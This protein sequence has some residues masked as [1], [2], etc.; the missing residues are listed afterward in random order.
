MID[1]ILKSVRA[2]VEF[3]V[4]LLSYR[5]IFNAT[6]VKNKYKIIAVG[7]PM[8]VCYFVNAYFQLNM[9]YT[10]IGAI[11]AILI[12]IFLLEG[13]KKKWLCLYP[14]IMLLA[15]MMSMA[16]SYAV[17]FVFSIP[18]V[19]V[20][21]NTYLSC[22]V[23]VI[24]MFLLLIGYFY[25]KKKQA[26]RSKDFKIS[27]IVYLIMTIGELA[28]TLLLGAMQ[29]YTEHHQVEDNMVNAIGFVIAIVCVVY[30]L[31][32]LF[33]AVYMQKNSEMKKEKDMLN[34]YISEQQ[35]HIE[36]M[37]EKE[38]DMKKFRHDVRQHMGIISYHLDKG[39]TD[40]ASEYISQIYENIDATKMVHY[41]GVVPID[42][43][44]YD[45][46]REMDNKNITFN[47]SGSV[48]KIPG[49]IQEY[50]ICTVF[51]AILD[52]AIKECESLSLSERELKLLVE[53]NNGKLYIMEKH[54]CKSDNA[55]KEDLRIRGIAEK[56]DG[57]VIYTE[58]DDNYMVEVVL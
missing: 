55:D 31:A 28:F 12:P 44:I 39:D 38:Q 43:V 24:F 32:F 58:S 50:D 45:K 54:K 37:V 17:A 35:K 15:S 57:Y 19:H 4:I 20:Y 3:L 1:S 10:L 13:N 23:D 5:Q 6:V 30:G 46:K 41:T 16:I 2:L 22:T 49:N 21:Y 29:F 56:Y 48:N 33:L 36:L 14:T 34:L 9:L 47:W 27:P 52:K 7:V 25:T 42:V 11:Y 26:S 40:A 8:G 18:V 53:I 51:I